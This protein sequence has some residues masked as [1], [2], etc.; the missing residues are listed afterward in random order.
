MQRRW[1]ISR[2]NPEFL[3]YL[4]KAASVSPVLAQI[5]VNR[6]IRTPDA[7]RDFLSPGVTALSDPFDLPGMRQAVGRVREA[8]R[9]S[10][11]VLVHGDYDT[12]GLTATAIMVHV[13]RTIGIE[14]NYFIP[15]RM[16]HGYGFHSHAINIAKKTGAGLIITVDCGITSFETASSA[17]ANGIDVIITDHHEP[18][19]VE[20]PPVSRGSGPGECVGDFILPEAVAVVN[21][22]LMAGDS[23][24]GSLAGAGVAL[25]FAQALAMEGIPNFPEDEFFSLFDLAALGTVADVVPL[26][27]ENRI[28][29]REGLKFIKTGDRPGIRALK[30]V[31]RLGAREIKAGSLAFTV[32]P[33]INAAGRLTDSG[34][35]VRLLL[36]ERQEESD[37]LSTWLDGLNS[38]RQRIEEQVYQEAV[39]KVDASEPGPAIIIAA[40]GWHQGVVG[41]VASRMTERY[42]R[43]AFVLSVKDGLATGSA[44]SVPA[45]D[46]CRGL[47]G[48][49]DFL[50][51][52]G[53]HRQAAGLTMETCHMEDFRKAMGE[54]VQREVAGD[55][56]VPSLEIDASV[57]L[58]DVTHT[59]VKELDLLEPVGYG[60]PEP[61]LGARDLSV[62]NPRVV[63]SKHLKLTVKKNSQTVDAIGFGMAA[64]YDDLNFPTSIDAV[65]TPG[66]NEWKGG[67]YLQLFLKA[68][69]PSV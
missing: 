56:C 67:R 20:C 10:E 61:L 27:G 69:R 40:E 47:A 23:G 1:F 50:L 41:I 18:L 30:D 51:S 65:F 21:P 68:F 6:G 44:R 2:T 13:L 55:Q 45:F 48:C 62:V 12:D 39:E 33:R 25:K 28:I 9:R 43:P 35:V 58:A 4:S 60:N 22:K 37:E 15:H 26:N 34:D 7:V 54:I 59:L 42:G 17:K 16:V 38:E 14:A 11:R 29:L 49:K 31:C 66:I 24:L 57:R 52:F 32:V 5:L 63:G 64:F 8:L 19:A 46:I 3:G 53:G 36:S